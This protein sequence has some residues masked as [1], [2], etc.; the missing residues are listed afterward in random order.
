MTKSKALIYGLFGLA[1]ISSAVWAEELWTLEKCLE[2]AKKT[3]LQLESARLR[4]QTA[5]IAIRQSQI[6]N[7]PSLNAQ[8]G[9]TIYDHPLAN[10]PQDHYRFNIGISGSMTLWDGGSA[11][12]SVEANQLSKE[13]TLFATKQTERTI[14]E[15][16]I[17]AYMNLLAASEKL[18][19]ADASILLAQAEYNNYE[20][21]FDAGLITRKDLTQSQSNVLQKQA[22]QL[23]AQL[24]VNTAKTTLR[25]LMELD[26]GD[27]LKISAPETSITSP[28][29]LP[30]LPPFEQLLADA[31][32][33]NPGIKSDSIS[34]EAAKKSTV[35]AGKGQSISVT[36]GA[37]SS[38]G[39]VGFES[40]RYGTQLKEGWQNSLSLNIN[41]PIIDNGSTNNKVLQA[42]VNETSAQLTLQESIKKLENSLE[43]L[44]IN[45]L[46]ADMQW[47]AAILQVQAET[48]ALAV[49]EEQRNAGAITYTDFLIQKNSL[50][51]AQVTLT[52][53]KYTSL[54]ARKL[55]EL[56]QGK[57][58]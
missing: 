1:T 44:Y 17:N 48:E 32:N 39:F 57:L 30:E 9:N 54:L 55:L 16:V 37:N 20:I 41:I 53:A 31:R 25:Q 19:T 50:E 26:S 27:S 18:T 42:Q 7:R 8:I 56:Y 29:S 47:K 13:A 5:D 51:N 46:S 49:A 45:A 35:V 6:S 21:L 24:S 40:D 10:H 22:A 58:D 14:Q 11:S 36:L 28:D 2:Q 12:L 4:E 33:A 34:I 52:N 38:T 23:T 43:K 3:S 15:S